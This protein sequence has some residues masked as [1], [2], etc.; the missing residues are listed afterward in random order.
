M[1][2]TNSF[3]SIEFNIIPYKTAKNTLFAISYNNNI[4]KYN[5][6]DK[7]IFDKLQSMNSVGQINLNV[8]LFL[9]LNIKFKIYIIKI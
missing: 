8:T 6:K 2:S 1:E 7:D 5:P 3:N 4:Y 9:K